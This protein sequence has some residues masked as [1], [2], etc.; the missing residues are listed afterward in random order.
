MLIRI[1]R[2]TF[3]QSKVEEFK[4]LFDEVQTKIQNFPGCQH[5]ELCADVSDSS[6]FYTFSK[7]DSEEA[8]EAYRTSDF[9]DDTWVR[10]KVLFDGKAE[11][12]SLLSKN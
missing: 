8:L 6:V 7:W 10:T 3:D 4:L 2:M 1:V 5:V 11:A 12:Y 9:F